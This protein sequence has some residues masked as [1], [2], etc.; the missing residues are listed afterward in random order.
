MARRSEH[1]FRGKDLTTLLVAGTTIVYFVCMPKHETSEPQDSLTPSQQAQAA[2]RGATLEP[3]RGQV[4]RDFTKPFEKDDIVYGPQH[5]MALGKVISV[6]ET[7]YK[8][9]APPP[10]HIG[11]RYGQDVTVW[12]IKS[13]ETSVHYGPHLNSAEALIAEQEAK[14]AGHRIRLAHA[15]AQEPPAVTASTPKPPT[16]K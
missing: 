9:E 12:W 11:T 5:G 16:L 1:L 7:R 14:T 2:F 8:G 10:R 3:G 6:A 15:K 13:G 4:L